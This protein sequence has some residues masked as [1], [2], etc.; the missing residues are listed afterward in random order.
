MASSENADIVTVGPL[1]FP[2]S[3]K[4]SYFL[5]RQPQASGSVQSAANN[6]HCRR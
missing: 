1:A 4:S 3:S 2:A 6:R 5:N